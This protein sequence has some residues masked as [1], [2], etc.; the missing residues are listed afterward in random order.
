LTIVDIPDDIEWQIEE[1]DGMEW[2]AE[3]HRIWQ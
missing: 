2:V 1:Y 3:V